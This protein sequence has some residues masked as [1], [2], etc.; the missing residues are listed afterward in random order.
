[1]FHEPLAPSMTKSDFQHRL[2]E[3]PA[4]A[5][6]LKSLGYGDVA[7]PVFFA[8]FTE[9]S[10]DNPAKAEWKHLGCDATTATASQS[11]FNSPCGAPEDDSLRSMRQYRNRVDDSR[12]YIVSDVARAM[13]AK[14]ENSLV[15]D[16]R[17]DIS[18]IGYPS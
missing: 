11:S 14:S 3:R 1:M 16:R 9:A 10:E 13:P 2:S 12:F 4:R 17:L 8:A 15:D 7:L 5:Y 18:L 6:S